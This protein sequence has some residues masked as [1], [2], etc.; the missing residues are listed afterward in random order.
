M[1]TNPN[2]RQIKDLSVRSKGKVSE[3]NIGQ[4]LHDIELG[5]VFL[6]V[7]PKTQVT[8]ENA[9]NLNYVK[10]FIKTLFTE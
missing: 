3:E 10:I 5:N 7:T 1:K 4:K 6:D 9:D 8:K 2:S